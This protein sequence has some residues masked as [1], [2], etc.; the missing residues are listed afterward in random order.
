L[1]AREDSQDH[2][3]RLQLCAFAHQAGRQDIV[4]ENAKHRQEHENPKQM[5]KPAQSGNYQDG[6]PCRQWPYNRNKLKEKS[7]GR[8]KNSL[9][10]AD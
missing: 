7:D 3:H 9:R 5:V 4:L 1:S 6:D 2:H 10:D 8:Q